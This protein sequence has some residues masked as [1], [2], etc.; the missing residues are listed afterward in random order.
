MFES[1]VICIVSHW[2]CAI[3]IEWV[4]QC[5]INLKKIVKEQ[6][7]TAADYYYSANNHCITLCRISKVLPLNNFAATIRIEF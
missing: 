6:K 5:S 7:F 3:R 2:C 1:E 4:K